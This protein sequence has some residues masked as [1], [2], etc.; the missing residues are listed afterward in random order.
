MP[1]K[2]GGCKDSG[3]MAPYLPLAVAAAWA[4]PRLE[5]GLQVSDGGSQIQRP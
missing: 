4:L 3:G 5:G 2:L 1:A